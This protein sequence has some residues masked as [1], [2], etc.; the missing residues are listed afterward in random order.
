MGKRWFDDVYDILYNHS[1]SWKLPG[2]CLWFPAKTSSNVCLWFPS[3]VCLCLS[4]L[5]EALF[6]VSVF[7][8]VSPVAGETHFWERL[9]RSPRCCMVSVFGC[10]MVSVIAGNMFC[11]W[12]PSFVV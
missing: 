8:M 1:G 10:F 2:H 11:L 12:F 4:L 9:R 6:M 7:L 3:F 5:Q